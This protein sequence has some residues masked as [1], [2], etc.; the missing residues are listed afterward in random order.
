MTKRVG[1]HERNQ[2]EVEHVQQ[3][4]WD[5]GVEGKVDSRDKGVDGEVEIRVLRK[6]RR[7]LPTEEKRNP[8]KVIPL[9]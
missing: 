8:S 2:Q 9:K 4:S 6:G 7:L 1:S 3:D 5:K